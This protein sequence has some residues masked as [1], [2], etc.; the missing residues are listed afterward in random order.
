MP[1]R[2][3]IPLPWGLRTLGDDRKRSPELLSPTER[4]LCGRI[5]AY[6]LHATHDPRETSLHGRQTFLAS[7]EQK[8][9]PDNTL[10]LAERTRRALA[11][12]KAHFARLALKS[13][14]VRRARKQ[15][16]GGGDNGG[17]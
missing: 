5:G 7:F 16:N 6:Q 1:I 11:A 17:E 14:Q 3:A 2:A 8:V 15:R 12:R 13:A 10:S 9:D 4:S